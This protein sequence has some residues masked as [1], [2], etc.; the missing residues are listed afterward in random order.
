MRPER[1][2]AHWFAM[3]AA[4]AYV[5]LDAVPASQPQNQKG[6]TAIGFCYRGHGSMMTYALVSY[7]YDLKRRD[8]NFR[9]WLEDP[10]SRWLTPGVE[11]SGPLGQGF[12][13]G[14]VWHG[15]RDL[16]AE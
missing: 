5:A 6:R 16:G 8:Q 13:T 15:S 2:R 11:I 10:A 12:A 9:R 1:S 7:G 14:V 4:Q 3:G